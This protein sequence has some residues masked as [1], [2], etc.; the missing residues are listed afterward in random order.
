MEN[1][2]ILM[3]SEQKICKKCNQYPAYFNSDLCMNCIEE[4]KQEEE[5]K[6]RLANTEKY[7]LRLGFPR[8]FISWEKD[9]LLPLLRNL[10]IYA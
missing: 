5:R 4:E 8:R 6:D 2:K 10:L 1:T 7:M 9:Q 3:S